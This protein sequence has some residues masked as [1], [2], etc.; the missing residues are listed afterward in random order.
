MW[1]DGVFKERDVF[2]DLL[3]VVKG[4]VNKIKFYFGYFVESFL[5]LFGVM[6]YGD[7]VEYFEVSFVDF[8]FGDL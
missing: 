8:I 2:Y 4:Y 6:V 7:E 3:G 1:L 5:V